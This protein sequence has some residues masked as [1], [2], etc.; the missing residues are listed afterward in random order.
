MDRLLYGLKRAIT[1]G[2][3]GAL[4]SYVLESSVFVILNDPTYILL[5]RLCSLV[6][7]V[8]LFSNMNYWGTLYALGWIVGVFFLAYHNLIGGFDFFMYVIAAGLVLFVRAERSYDI[9]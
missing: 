5:S 8:V 3:P 2:G 6:G 7:M 4:T 9:F 1:E